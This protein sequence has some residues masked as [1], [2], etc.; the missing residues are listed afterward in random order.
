MPFP[1]SRRA[2]LLAA[3]L[4][5][6]P[7][8]PS[9]Q[10]AGQ[11]AEAPA[12]APQEE[13]QADISTV[14]ATVDG[15]DVTL[16]EIIMMRMNLPPQYQE[17]PDAQLYEALV[18]Q[19]VTQRLLAADAREAG[20]GDAPMARLAAEQAEQT[21]LAEAKMREVVEAATSEEKLRAEYERRME[22]AEPVQ[23]VKASHILVPTREE[24]Q[25][26]YEEAQ[27]GADFAELAR[28]HGTDG[29]KDR[30]GD[31]GWF[32]KEQM[33]PAFAEVAFSAEEGVV[34]EPVQTDFG[35]HLIKVTGKRE[36]PAP[37]FEAVRDEIAQ[38]LASGA[39]QRAIVEVREGAEIAQPETGLDPSVIR[40]DDLLTAN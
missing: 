32:E 6:L 11:P 29:T 15:E 14:V 39:A 34:T 33:V 20:Y 37:E 17:L 19:A 7:F 3:A 10:Q 30:G 38:D 8:A 36:Q 16:G 9:A 40:R 31:L 5:A 2:A 25:A 4:T 24:A 28:E 27:G 1:P 22:G 26:I 21:Y 13:A 23:E 35:W 18:E 12:A